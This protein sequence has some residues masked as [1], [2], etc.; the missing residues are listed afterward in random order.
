M[1]VTTLQ[2]NRRVLLAGAFGQSN[3]GDEALLGAFARALPDHVAVVASAAPEQTTAEHGLA[4]VRRDDAVALARTLASVDAVVVAGGTIF[5][6]LHPAA[7]R[8]RHALLARTAALAAVSRALRKPLALVGVGAG[9]LDGAV[10][11]RL[12]RFIVRSSDLL[13]L[14]DDESADRLA[15]AGAP[16]PFRVGSDAAWT[17]VGAPAGE[18]TE[19]RAT[20]IA[21][22]GA[23]GRLATVEIDEAAPEAPVVVA[24]SHLAGG[25]DLA[26]RLAEGLEPVAAERELHLQPWQTDV[27]HGGD[28]A[29][30]ADVAQR[31]G[32]HATVVAPPKDLLDARER[33]ADVGLVV[34]LRFHA[35]PAAAAA[36]TPVLGV[37]HEPKLA[38]AARR[39]GQP[40]VPATAAPDQLSSAVLDA[41]DGPAPD[42]EAV[43][44]EC[45]RAEEGFRLL[46]VLL[47]RGRSD[48]AADVD[49]LPLRPEEWLG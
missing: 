16:A 42:A 23:G 41:L 21:M 38:G 10:A 11:R 29:L 1:T 22:R 24:L 45:D 3:P 37:A 28:E 20:A 43:A 6:T 33:F 19:E 44:A 7:G 13:V 17:L 5:K 30:A 14:R 12:A 40:T 2:P 31:L 39:L 48:E 9:A 34:A 49:G 25:D 47:A 35:I 18:T 32:D 46:R 36:G 26:A 15:E 4:A 8:A 27:G